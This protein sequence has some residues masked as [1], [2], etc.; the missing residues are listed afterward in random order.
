MN[1]LKGEIRKDVNGM[2]YR[3]TKYG[4]IYE[5]ISKSDLICGGYHA[6]GVNRRD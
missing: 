2:P 3:Q 5:R 4:R 1:K 6:H